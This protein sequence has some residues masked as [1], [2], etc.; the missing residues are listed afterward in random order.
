MK[1]SLLAALAV[2]LTLAVSARP[3]EAQYKNVIVNSGNG[4][5][6]RI[7]AVNHGFGGFGQNTILNSGNGIGNTIVARTGGGFGQGNVI[8]VR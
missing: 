3:A 1:R 4:Q 2:A 6:N 8:I 5:G 7:V